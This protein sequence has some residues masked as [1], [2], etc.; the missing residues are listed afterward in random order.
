[1]LR[2]L[3]LASV[4][5]TV[6]G[7]V[8]CVRTPAQ[9][10]RTLPKPVWVLVILLLPV[11]GAVVWLLAGKNRSKPGG[12]PSPRPVAPDDDP[13]FLRRIDE[14]RRREQRRQ[15]RAERGDDRGD[16]GTTPRS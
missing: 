12:R 2:F 4:A 15:E 16:E 7:V 13:D 14:Q 11:L 10:V 8:D 6:Y 3:V 1:M 5:I 9:R